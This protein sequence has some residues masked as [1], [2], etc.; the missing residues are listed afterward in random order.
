MSD[1]TA[2]PATGESWSWNKFFGGF[3]NGINTAKA[4]QT[5]VHQVY[6]IVIIGSILFVGV[7]AWKHFHKP[8]STPPTPPI[9]VTTNSG[10][11]STSSD[12]RRKNCWI[13]NLCW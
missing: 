13:L 8:K 4:I 3:L 10:K 12:D 9:S 6:L 5:T 7:T 11:I 1:E 2:A